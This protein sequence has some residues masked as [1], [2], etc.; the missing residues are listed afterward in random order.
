MAEANERWDR[1]NVRMYHIDISV[2]SRCLHVVENS[3]N[4]AYS[5]CY[6][7]TW[8]N[9]FRQCACNFRILFNFWIEAHLCKSLK[10]VRNKCLQCCKTLSLVA[11]I[12]ARVKSNETYATS[13][14][15]SLFLASYKYTRYSYMRVLNSVI[16]F[17]NLI[18]LCLYCTIL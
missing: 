17:V 13:P 2:K 9:M 12:N 10:C 16:I 4:I 1:C 8:I 18:K 11:R 14:L 7:N 5:Q 3:S 6:I 15:L